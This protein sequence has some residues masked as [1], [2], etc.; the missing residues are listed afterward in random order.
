MNRHNRKGD[1]AGPRS[2]D[3]TECSWMDAEY[4]PEEHICTG[5]PDRAV[6]GIERIVNSKLMV[7]F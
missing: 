4:C 1:Q 2:N 5:S 6:V 3:R 7:K